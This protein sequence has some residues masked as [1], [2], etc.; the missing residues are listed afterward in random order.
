MALVL[1]NAGVAFLAQREHVYKLSEMDP[2]LLHQD[3]PMHCAVIKSCHSFAPVEDGGLEVD[4]EGHA[5]CRVATLVREVA[6]TGDT[7]HSSSAGALAARI[8]VR[9]ACCVA[10]ATEVGVRLQVGAERPRVG[11][12]GLHWW[13]GLHARHCAGTCV[14]TITLIPLFPLNLDRLRTA[15]HASKQQVLHDRLP[16]QDS[17]KQAHV[18][19][20]PCAL[21][22]RVSTLTFGYRGNRYE[23]LND[24]M[25]ALL[26]Q[27]AVCTP[28]MVAH[29]KPQAPQLAGSLVRSAHMPLQHVC[30]VAH[31][32]PQSP[33][34]HTHVLALGTGHH[35]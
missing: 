20:A 16:W 14:S 21:L 4:A 2:L 12:A 23:I 15:P 25:G 30:P 29:L 22:M 13:V 19:S 7:T 34:L 11:R 27:V 33:Q 31:T 26:L 28:G 8:C 10:G 24:D 5:L 32:T 6:V 35:T 9:G 17:R 3:M 18:L 1:T